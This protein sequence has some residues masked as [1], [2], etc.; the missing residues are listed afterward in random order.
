MKQKTCGWLLALAL[1]ALGLSASPLDAAT[2]AVPFKGDASGDIVGIPTGEGLNYAVEIDGEGK[3]TI[4]GKFKLSAT[5]TTDG[6][7]GLITDGSITFVTKHG[8][9]LTATY[10]GQEYP[11]ESPEMVHVIA[12]LTI[13]GGTGQFH[14]A[15]G[16][17]SFT[18]V[19]TIEEMTDEGVFIETFTASLD[20]ELVLAR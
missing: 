12:T 14:G 18:A 10:T 4:L 19:A 2:A 8:D 5:H 17:G 9:T 16:S 3:S 15:T 20:A 7:T 13:T 11:G 1:I 6:Y